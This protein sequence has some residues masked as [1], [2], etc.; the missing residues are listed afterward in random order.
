MASRARQAFSV[1]AG[2]RGG[3]DGNRGDAGEC[4]GWFYEESFADGFIDFRRRCL[5][6]CGV[7][8]HYVKGVFP[9]DGE[10]L[11]LDIFARLGED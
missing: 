2:V 3:H 7:F 9:A 10:F 6:D 5:E 4:S 8:R 1:R 11:R